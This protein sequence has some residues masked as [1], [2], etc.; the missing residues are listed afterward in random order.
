MELKKYAL[1]NVCSIVP[2]Y[3]FKSSDFGS[4]ENI[5]IKI[6]DIEPPYVNIKNAERVCFTP[7]DKFRLSQGDFVMAMTGATIGKVGKLELD[8]K[9]VYI[10]QRVCKFEPITS[11]CDKK[12]LYYVLST[13]S[14]RN[15]IYNNIDSKLAQ[16][17]IGHPTIYKYTHLFPINIEE[18]K[19]VAS[20]LNNLDRK[21]ELNRQINDNLPRLDRSLKEAEVRLVA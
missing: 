10:N 11:V 21:I 18:Q 2:G 4:G 15:F 19:L 14:F 8:A 17:N 16:P 5:A 6:K 13:P 12:Y 20:V 3:A 1:S 9:N 7:Q